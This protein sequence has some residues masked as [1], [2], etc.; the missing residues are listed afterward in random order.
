MMSTKSK[1]SLEYSSD[2]QKHLENFVRSSP[3][4]QTKNIALVDDNNIESPALPTKLY[5]SNIPVNCS[6]RQLTEFF[7]TFGQ[8][9]E[10]AIMWDKY[11]FVHYGSTRDARKALQLASGALFMGKLLH[12]Q[13]STSRYRQTCDWYQQQQQQQQQQQHQQHAI[14]VPSQVATANAACVETK[15]HVS[16]L[17]E[18]CDHREL[19]SLF[20]N[21]GKVLECVVMWNQYAFVH[22]ARLSEAKSAINALNGKLFNGKN[23][24]VQLS[25]SLNRPLPKCAAFNN[26]NNDNNNNENFDFPNCIAA[27]AAAVNDRLFSPERK[28]NNNSSKD[29]NLLTSILC[30][31]AFEE[32]KA[33]EQPPNEI[34]W[35]EIIKNGR[36]PV[37]QQ[38]QAQSQEQLDDNK[39]NR[40]L[41]HA[42]I[43]PTTSAHNISLSELPTPDRP[44]LSLKIPSSASAVKSIRSI[45]MKSPFVRRRHHNAKNNL[46]NDSMRVALDFEE[47]PVTTVPVVDESENVSLKRLIERINLAKSFKN[48]PPNELEKLNNN[49]APLTQP[50]IVSTTTA[51]TTSSCSSSS[52]HISPLSSRKTSTSDSS[53]MLSPVELSNFTNSNNYAYNLENIEQTLE[54][55]SIR[56]IRSSS[57]TNNSSQM[58]S[59]KNNSETCYV[60]RSSTID[61]DDNKM[62]KLKRTRCKVVNY[63][64]FPELSEQYY[65]TRKEYESE[66]VRLIK[67]NCTLEN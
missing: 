5:V 46:V 43:T 4:K 18:N 37:K 61:E 59:N 12:I 3:G 29:K 11:A 8:V 39:K 58:A 1:R 50:Q 48:P 34:N 53:C 67:K 52:E 44:D 57:S 27:P 28:N 14:N 66:L 62:V 64:L 22:F 40:P 21:Y 9:L 6:R 15:L 65:S 7:S 35:I 17:P 23:L 63:I 26:N 32:N 33:K 2:E 16:N 20:D 55:N 10:C 36:L 38:Q 30:Y 19:K 13:L 24:I 56:S 31:R 42:A 41:I 60:R 25:T 51:I 54:Q 49:N 47:N 45:E